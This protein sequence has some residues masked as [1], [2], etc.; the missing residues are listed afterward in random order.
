MII[1]VANG[2]AIGDIPAPTRTPIAPI[3]IAAIMQLIIPPRY[4]ADSDEKLLSDVNAFRVSLRL[5]KTDFLLIL[6]SLSN[7]RAERVQNF[8]L[9]PYD[10]K[11]ASSL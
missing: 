1:P 6:H 9:T 8:K 3:T 7:L 5:F 2:T 4:D 11:R 10:F